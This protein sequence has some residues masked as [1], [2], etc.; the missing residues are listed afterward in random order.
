M[1]V[2]FAAIINTTIATGTAIMA[3]YSWAAK[4]LGALEHR[5]VRL[6]E[7]L[8]HLQY[9]INGNTELVKHRTARFQEDKDQILG[10]IAEL[11]TELKLAKDAQAETHERAWAAI[12][13]IREKTEKLHS[14]FVVLA[15]CSDSAAAKAVLTKTIY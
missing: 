10:L 2:D 15:E 12:N 8:E 7:E 6:D 9:L 5:H 11:Q 4:R 3:M 1:M 14:A 13:K